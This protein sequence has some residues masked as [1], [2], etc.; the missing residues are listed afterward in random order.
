MD[1]TKGTAILTL[2][3]K[4]GFPLLSRWIKKTMKPIKATANIPNTAPIATRP[5]E[6]T[7]EVLT[8]SDDVVEL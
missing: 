1:I 2:G 6:L 8:F 4:D 3:P 5:D 7:E